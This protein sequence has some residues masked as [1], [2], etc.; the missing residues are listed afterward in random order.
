MSP[1]CGSGTGRTLKP[2]WIDSR[3]PAPSLALATQASWCPGATEWFSVLYW[4]PAGVQAESWKQP[5]PSQPNPLLSE[6]RL[7]LK[8]LAKGPLNRQTGRFW[9]RWTYLEHSNGRRK[10]KE[11]WDKGSGDNLFFSPFHFL[12]APALANSVC[13]FVCLGCTTQ[14]V[15]SWFPNQELSPCPLHWECKVLTTRLPGKSW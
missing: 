12:S 7:P 15:G 8:S 1:F 14:H 10:V 9:A 13:L 11:S 5:C 3:G 4:G 6:L 2:D